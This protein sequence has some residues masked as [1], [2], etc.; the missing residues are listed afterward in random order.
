MLSVD[1]FNAFVTDDKHNTTLPAELELVT[2]ALKPEVLP[3]P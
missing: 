2:G 1:E 3:V